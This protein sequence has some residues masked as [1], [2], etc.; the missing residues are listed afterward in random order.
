MSVA[1]AVNWRVANQEA[2]NWWQ[3]TKEGDLFFMMLV[4]HCRLR[5]SRTTI[6]NSKIFAHLVVSWSFDDAWS[7]PVKTYRTLA[8][9]QAQH[10][11]ASQH[12]DWTIRHNFNARYRERLR[13][14]P[15]AGYLIK[16]THGKPVLSPLTHPYEYFEASERLRHR[17]H[18]LTNWNTANK[19]FAG[20]PRMIVR[21]IVWDRLS[22]RTFAY[23]FGFDV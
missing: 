9:A 23:P 2:I 19:Y 4:T 20:M 18:L 12:T 16:G 5:E 21:R 10:D 8:A 1:F 6:R 17:W 22:D 15:L 7:E 13:T 11:P 14:L 3:V